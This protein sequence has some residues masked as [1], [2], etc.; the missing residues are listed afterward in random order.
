MNSSIASNTSEY[1][2]IEI[3]SSIGT[4]Q[5]RLKNNSNDEIVNQWTFQWEKFKQNNK[6]WTFA[7]SQIKTPE[8]VCEAARAWGGET[9][10]VSRSESYIRE[11]LKL[12]GEL[13]SIV[14]N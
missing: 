1:E 2:I 12:C 11:T 14:K 9:I 3:S 6:V 7:Y 10:L 8:N 13:I 4:K 5:I